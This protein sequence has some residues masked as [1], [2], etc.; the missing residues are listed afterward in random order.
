M[1][2]SLRESEREDKLLRS[3]RCAGAKAQKFFYGIYGTNKFVPLHKANARLSNILHSQGN[4]ARG[5]C[6]KAFRDD[7]FIA[8]CTLCFLHNSNA[9]PLPSSWNFASGSLELK[10]LMFHFSRC[11]ECP[12]ARGQ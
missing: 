11:V 12:R 1:R 3:R 10:T 6:Y 9:N 8:I 5:S 7:H 2:E 4:F